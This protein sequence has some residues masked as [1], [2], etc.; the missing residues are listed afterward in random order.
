MKSKKRIVCFG[1]GPMFKGGIANYNTSLAKAFDKIENTEVHIVSWTQQYPAIIPRDFIDRKSKVDQLEG[2]NIN[3]HYITNYNNPLSWKATVKLIK[4]LNPDKVIFQWAIAIQGI[5]LGF[6]AKNLKKESNIEVFF[7][8][9]FVIQ[10]EGS[11]LD[12]RLTR[13]GIINADSY[14]VHAFKTA[15]ELKQLFPK[16]KFEIIKKG[17]SI[18]GDGIKV[19]KL[20]HPVY[21]M[22]K[23][24]SNFDKSKTKKE[25]GLKENV[26]LFFGFIRKYKGLHNVIEAFNI[27]SNERDDVSLIICG[28][29]FWN[30][31]D[32]KKLSTRIKNATFGLAKK[33]FLR[34]QDNEQDYNPLALIE[35]YQ[36]D[37]LVFLNNEFVPNEEVPKYF[38]VSDTIM[39]YYLTATPSGVES[40]GY[41]FNMP[42]LA[43][44]V[45]HFPETVIDGYNGYMAEANDIDSM[46]KAMNKSI[47]NPIDRKN[48]AATSKDM[49]WNNY[50]NEIL[51]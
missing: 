10:K 13:L 45:G 27:L 37:D 16:R 23:P 22:F 3:V 41:N 2:T 20:Y 44:N 8:L 34:N 6:I 30:T 49:S 21:D 46:V 36:I 9:H 11:A 29:S 35:D 19:L 38:Q 48:V 14:I 5:P 24:D 26:F 15:E 50:A 4:S 25:M 51:R 32:K 7:D 33:L 18:E 28:E 1:P 17:D 42:M 47:E 31:L 43:T 12:N 40:I 39:L